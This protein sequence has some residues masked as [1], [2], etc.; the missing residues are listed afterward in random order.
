MAASATYDATGVEHYTLP[1]FTF[2][3]G[4]THPNIRVAYRSHNPTGKKGCVLIPTCYGGVIN[5]T[6]TFTAGPGNDALKDHHVIV[7]A[8][9]GN[10]ESSSPSNYPGFPQPGELHYEDC[11]RSQHALLTQH[12]GIQQLDAVIGFSMGAQQ[13]YYWSVMYPAFMKAAIPICGSARTSP[14]NYAFLEGPI[15]ALSN[16]VDYVAWKEIQAKV[17]RGE[18]VGPKLQAVKPTRGIRAFGRA[19]NAWRTST[20]W[21]RERWWGDGPDGPGGE[22]RWFALGFG[23]VEEY[24]VGSSEAG[25]LA[26]NADDLLVLARMWQMGD[27]SRVMPGKEMEVAGLGGKSGDDEM[28]KSAL[29]SVQARMLVMPCR[30][31]QYFLPEDSEIEV[32]YLQR[33]ELAVVESVWG[34]VAGGGANFKDTEYM[35]E[36]IG[37]FLA[38]Q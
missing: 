32:P 5:S 23:S 21:F 7:V 14:H 31:D 34:H 2:A 22:S 10:G 37:K 4:K 38:R 15:A 18:D 16:S 30:T 3:N 13:T 17:A 20:R 6:L 1:S 9:L 36:R 35:N 11:I 26:W 33:G 29:G 8:M 28:F 25:F 27:V 12:L 24:I 19:Y